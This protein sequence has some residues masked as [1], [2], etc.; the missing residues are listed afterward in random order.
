MTRIEYTSE[1]KAPIDKVFAFIAE[2]TNS[3]KWHPSVTKAE[4]ISQGPLKVGSK[5]RM[6]AVVS[7]RR[8]SWDQE[9]IEFTPNRSFRDRMITGPF[10]RYEDWATFSET[11]QGTRWIFGLQY[12]LTGGLFGK[13]IDMLV[14]GRRVRRHTQEAMKRAK[15]ILEGQ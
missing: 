11:D 3:P 13:I 12:E 7:R 4:R 5:L 15:E 6:E 8:Y 1:I 10:K 2:G 9:V 14:I